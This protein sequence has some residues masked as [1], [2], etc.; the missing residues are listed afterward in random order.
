[1]AARNGITGPVNTIPVQRIP[2]TIDRVI[3]AILRR[4]R[5]RKKRAVFIGS[6]SSGK[7]TGEAA[8][9]QGVEGLTDDSLQKRRSGARKISRHPKISSAF[10]RMLIIRL[11]LNVLVPLIIMDH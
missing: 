2:Q 3:L 7:P 5:G 6:R 4:T 11:N 10:E 8:Q 9:L 1:V